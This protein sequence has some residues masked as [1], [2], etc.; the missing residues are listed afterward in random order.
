MKS[1]YSCITDQV[2]TARPPSRYRLVQTS[3]AG[4]LSEGRFDSR[5]RINHVP[6]GSLHRDMAEKFIPAGL[7]VPSWC[8]PAPLPQQEKSMA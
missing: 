6:A 4:P 2:N 5:V 7:G 1:I 3:K 8:P